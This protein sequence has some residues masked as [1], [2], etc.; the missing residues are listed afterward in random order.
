M[1]RWPD[2]SLR[3]W[4]GFLAFMHLGLTLRSYIDSGY[5]YERVFS[6]AKTRDPLLVRFFGAFSLGQTFVLLQA[7]IHLYTLPVQIVAMC[8]LI[9]FMVFVLIEAFYFQTM[10]FYGG[11]LLSWIM[12]GVSLIWMAIF[13]YAWKPWLNE[14]IKEEITLKSLLHEGKK[15]VKSYKQMSQKEKEL[16]KTGRSGKPH[17]D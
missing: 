2:Y 12:S 7:A 6:L 9:I 15:K 14:S 16:T 5:V 10:D 8:A 4:L 11:T 1:A 17:I 3:G 13:H